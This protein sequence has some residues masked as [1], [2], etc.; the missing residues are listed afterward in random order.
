MS[1]I[2]REAKK[3]VVIAI[4]TGLAENRQGSTALER[5]GQR[6]WTVPEAILSED[7]NITVYEDGQHTEMSKV[8]LA[9]IAWNDAASARQLLEHKNGLHLTHLELMTVA[10]KCLQSRR[11]VQKWKGD[12]TYALMGLLRIRPPIDTTDSSFQAFA[13]FVNMC[14]AVSLKVNTSQ[15]ILTSRQR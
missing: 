14:T 2:I 15:A 8:G 9:E 1:D 4:N 10:V 3:T 13:R 12:L 5:W 6:V 11:L 7:N